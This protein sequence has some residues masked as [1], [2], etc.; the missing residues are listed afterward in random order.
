ME[1]VSV[2]VSA[3]VEF[4]IGLIQA[5]TYTPGFASPALTE[6][7]EG[8]QVSCSGSVDLQVELNSGAVRKMIGIAIDLAGRNRDLP[9]ADGV[10]A[11]IREIERELPIYWSPHFLEQVWLPQF[12]R[13]WDRRLLREMSAAQALVQQFLPV[14]GE[15]DVALFLHEAEIDPAWAWL[16]SR[17]VLIPSSLVLSTVD[18]IVVDDRLLFTLPTLEW[19]PEAFSPQLAPEWT[20]THWPVD[21]LALQY[22]A[23]ACRTRLR[24]LMLLAIQ[25]HSIEQLSKALGVTQATAS[26]HVATLVQNG[27][28]RTDRSWKNVFAELAVSERTL[29][30]M[31]LRYLAPEQSTKRR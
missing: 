25:P 15:I 13:S 28:V 6:L 26:R 5:S 14:K 22:R 21:L 12:M 8:L 24:I 30:C 19:K 16:V 2:L 17:V 10:M 20:P 3:E 31:F 27:L 9:T 23:L 29:G 1:S 11:F 4:A 18:P 7:I